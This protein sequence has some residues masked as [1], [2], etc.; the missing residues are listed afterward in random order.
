VPSA[1]FGL[2]MRSSTECLLETAGEL[3]PGT[4]GLRF[5]RFANVE[6]AAAGMAHV[7]RF[8][9]LGCGR[10]VPGGGRGWPLPMGSEW[11]FEMEGLE[12]SC[13]RGSRDDD[14]DES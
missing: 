4:T 7:C 13:G 2:S 9:F 10:G 1:V 14:D 11:D 8:S 12:W 5:V 6:E 3:G